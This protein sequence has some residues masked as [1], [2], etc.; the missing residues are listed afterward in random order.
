MKLL[1]AWILLHEDELNANWELAKEG[2][3][4]FDIKPLQ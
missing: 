3:K 4:L 2:A 1:E